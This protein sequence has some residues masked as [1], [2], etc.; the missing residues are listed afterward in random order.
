MRRNL[1]RR[2]SH[3]L[4]SCLFVTSIAFAAES[5]PTGSSSES[6]PVGPGDANTL[7]LAEPLKPIP[8]APQGRRAARRPSAYKVAEVKDGGSITGVVLYQ[9]KTP[10]PRK[11]QIVKDHETCGKHPTEVPVMK[12][13][14]DGHVAE[15]VVYLANIE[16]GKGWP[17]D[18]PV[19][20]IDQ[21]T[22]E[23]EPHVQVVRARS[24]VEIVNS[25]PV[26]HNINASQRIYTLFNILQPQQGMRAK[27]QLDRP[28]VVNL[29]CNVHDWMQ[30]YVHVMTHPYYA[31]TGSDGKFTIDNIPPGKYELAVWQEHLDEQLWEVNVSPGKTVET[32]IVLK[33]K[34]GE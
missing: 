1:P 27:Q 13:D 22:C 12:T 34:E 4:V 9:G 7:A 19:P 2:L 15:A 14:K 16:S 24:E 6:K 30:G 17:A 25:D 18:N 10:S 33:P 11:I 31:V 5:P 21:R 20:T 3:Y 23:F 8:A 28:G 32:Q 26:A 29:K